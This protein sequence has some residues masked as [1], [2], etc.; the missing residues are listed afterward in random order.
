MNIYEKR[1]RAN[2]HRLCLKWGTDWDKAIRN[3]VCDAD[4][5]ARSIRAIRSMD[6]EQLT[7]KVG[8]SH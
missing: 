8:P 1:A 2:R 7:V 4:I 5:L 6:V 3:V